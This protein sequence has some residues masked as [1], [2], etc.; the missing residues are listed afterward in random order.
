ML[1]FILPVTKTILMHCCLQCFYYFFYFAVESRN[2]AHNV[3]DPEK[4]EA[5]HNL[6]P[7]PLLSSFDEK[8]VRSLKNSLFAN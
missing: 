6:F 3:C 8:R 7:K 5:L 4:N 1:A 2:I